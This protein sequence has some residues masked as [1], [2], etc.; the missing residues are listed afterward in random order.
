MG[1]PRR[2]KAPVMDLYRGM[3][4]TEQHRAMELEA[5]RRA[6]TIA[7]WWYEALTLKLAD[8]LRYTPDFLI[9]EN[10]GTLRLEEVKGFWRDDARGK[11]RMCVKLFPFRL[12]ALS[13]RKGG[14]WDVEDFNPESV[15][16]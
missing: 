12:S 10:D 5:M 13:K 14:G 9:Q 6:G 11:C 2:A 7:G 4:K 16:A 8:D 3:N 1:E 15:A